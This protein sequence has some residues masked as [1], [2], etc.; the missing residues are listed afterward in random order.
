MPWSRLRALA[1]AATKGLGAGRQALFSRWE[2]YGKPSGEGASDFPEAI[3]AATQAVKFFAILYCFDQ[4]VLHVT[5]V[6][7]VG[8]IAANHSATLGVRAIAGV[9][10]ID[11]AHPA[12]FG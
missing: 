10:T 8:A 4:Y 2:Q 9:W 5:A 6:R 1:A 3:A 11:D 12:S 7:V